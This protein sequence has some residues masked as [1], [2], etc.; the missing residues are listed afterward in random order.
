MSDAPSSSTG[1]APNVAGALSYVLGPITGVAFLVLEKESRFVRF[2]AAQSIGVS[3]A[4]FALNIVLMVVSGVLGVIPVL[5]WL[6]ALA[7]SMAV[8]FGSL[9]LWVYLMYQAF[10]G[11][12]WEVPVIGAQ[13]RRYLSPAAIAPPR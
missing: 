8:S 10:Q 2:H 12:E 1:L 7:L 6:I 5:G 3:I 4:L 9:G 11:Q 13:V